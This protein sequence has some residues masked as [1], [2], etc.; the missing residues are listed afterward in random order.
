M[1]CILVS[2]L[3]IIIHHVMCHIRHRNALRHPCTSAGV[4]TR[5][6]RARGRNRHDGAARHTVDV[7]V[8]VRVQL[9][10]LVHR[11]SAHSGCALRGRPGGGEHPVFQ[12]GRCGQATARPLLRRPG[13]RVGRACVFWA[14]ARAHR[15]M[16]PQINLHNCLIYV[17][18]YLVLYVCSLFYTF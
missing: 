1:E 7:A 2:L 3:D 18:I 15:P 12:R 4:P 10:V 5:C 6:A 16:D 13:R 11:S 17:L 9:R 8:L 14:K